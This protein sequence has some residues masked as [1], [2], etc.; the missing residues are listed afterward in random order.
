MSAEHDAR[1][2]TGLSSHRNELRYTRRASTGGAMLG[3]HVYSRIASIALFAAIVLAPMQ[4]AA[5]GGAT[6]ATLSGVVSDATGAVLPGVTVTLTDQATNLARV[7]VTNGTGLYRFA[8]LTPG[9]YSAA[10]EL[11]GFAKFIQKDLTLNVGA[12][13][14]LDMTLKVSTVE[15]AMTVTGEAP[16]VESAKTDLRGV[17]Q[18]DQLETLPTVDRNYLN[19]ALLVPGVN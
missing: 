19:Y 15:E 13:A 4:A 9:T 6:T 10:A 17:I 18:K 14:D 12:A 2:Y 8:G 3:R 5:Q 7:A 1:V 16:I 11:Q